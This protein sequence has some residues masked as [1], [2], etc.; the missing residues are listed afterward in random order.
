MNS[1]NGTDPAKT[2]RSAAVEHHDL[3]DA[4]LAVRRFGSGPALVFIHGFPTH[5]YTWRFLLPELA[6]NFT[7]YTVDLAGLGDS[8]FDARTDF[9]FTAQARRVAELLAKLGIERCALVAHDTGATIARLVALAEPSRV[10]RQALINTEIPGHRPPWIP[11]YC[12][13]AKLPG[14][15]LS[16]RPLLSSKWYVRSGMGF[17]AFYSDHSLFDDPTRLGPY[18]DPLLSS[19]ERMNGMLGYL[20]GIEWNVV[21]GLKERHASLQGPTL[22]LWGED[23]VTFP[24]AYAERM[25]PEFA[26]RAKLVRIPRASLMPHEERPEAV[27]ES[28]APFL[29][30]YAA[31]A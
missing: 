17:G 20:T 6:K 29:A 26:G 21:D 9:R 10:R 13:T 30:E 8:R 27:L 1:S 19:R 3:G 22:L 7:C 12:R 18:L 25:V 16:F 24:V 31:S 15:A 5:G 14:A 2:Y 4:S 23:D 28:L 11:L